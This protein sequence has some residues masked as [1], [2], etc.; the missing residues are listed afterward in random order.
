M[1]GQKS[2]LDD[3]M[4]AVYDELRRLAQHY[5]SRERAGH[6]LQTTALVHEA[7][8]RLVDQK[9]V[10]WQNRSQF[11]GI[12]AQMMRRILINHAR[13]RNAQ[14]RQG[15]ATKVSLDEA[16]SLFE[17]REVDLVALD[18]ALNALAALDPQQA[19]V[20]ELRFFGGLTIEEVAEVMDISPATTKREW[21]SAKLWLRRQLGN[22]R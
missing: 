21:D 6:T 12:A 16:I 3:L 13:E 8:L 19:Q 20:V 22:R 18:E 17:T 7:Y 15:Y 5:L 11:F 14:K 2:N 9:T 10:D 4:P 1:Q